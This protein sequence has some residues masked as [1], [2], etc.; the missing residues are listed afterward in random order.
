MIRWFTWSPHS[1]VVLIS[2]CMQFFI[3]STHR[4]GVV[5]GS[6]RDFMWRDGVEVRV[7]PHPDPQGVWA[8]AWS[9]LGKAYDWKYIYGWLL[10]RNWQ[11]PTKWSCSEL[12]A[13]AAKLFDDEFTSRVSPRDIYLISK[14]L[15]NSD[16]IYS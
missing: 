2:P 5:R 16:I 10:R 14:E 1:H 6:I 8:V 9:Q 12:I 15:P 11:D 13:W 7:I 4:K 3:E